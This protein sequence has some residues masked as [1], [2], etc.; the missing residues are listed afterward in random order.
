MVI[1]MSNAID[2][3]QDKLWASIVAG[4]P[5]TL[6]KPYLIV[7]P[8]VDDTKRVRAHGFGFYVDELPSDDDLV[9]KITRT[10]QSAPNTQLG[11]LFPKEQAATPGDLG[12]SY[13]CGFYA[14]NIPATELVAKVKQWAKPD[15]L[16]YTSGQEFHDRR[17]GPAKNKL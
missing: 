4:E 7:T 17:P 15:L 16:N 6:D 8:L 3:S 14:D 2:H 12:Q 13:W 10:Q 11:I 9:E 5:V 1:R